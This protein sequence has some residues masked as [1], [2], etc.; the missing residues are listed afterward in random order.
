M[1]RAIHVPTPATHPNPQ[2]RFFRAI[3]DAIP[4]DIF[5]VD[6]E[7]RLE[8]LTEHVA[9]KIGADPEEIL[10]DRLGE[11]L[12]CVNA[13]EAGCGFH[14]RCQSCAL[15]CGIE[16]AAKEQRRFQKKIRFSYR[17]QG[18]EH[19][20]YL[21]VTATPFAFEEQAPRV[22]LVLEDITSVVE[23]QGLLPI[24]AHC[25][26]IRDDDDYWQSL[27]RYL[28]AHSDALLT[29]TICDRCLERYYPEEEDEAPASA[30]SA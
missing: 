28:N 27:E 9:G 16:A 17:S 14:E 29:H 13:A 22:L 7:R 3:L 23:L 4:S 26:A 2:C 10:G 21:L 24:C 6:A 15:R 30:A 5:L 1:A 20:A 8:A 18:E 12:A 11:V 25:K 19:A